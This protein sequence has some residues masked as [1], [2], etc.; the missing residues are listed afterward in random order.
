M[1]QYIKDKRDALLD[2]MLIA[3][4]QLSGLNGPHKNENKEGEKSFASKEL[5]QKIA[6]SLVNASIE[7]MRSPS[8]DIHTS[9]P[10]AAAELARYLDKARTEAGNAM[11]NTVGSVEEPF[12]ALFL[13]KLISRLVPERLPEREH[14]QLTDA[15]EDAGQG[16][17][18]INTISVTT[19]ASNLGQ[20]SERMDSVFELQDSVVRVLAWKRPAT[21]IVS[22]LVFTKICY[23]PMYMALFPILFIVF[24]TCLPHYNRKHTYER[25]F[26]H[27]SGG[28]GRSLFNDLFANRPHNKISTR[29]YSGN[30]ASSTGAEENDDENGNITHGMKV[31]M[32]LRDLQ[33]LTTS[34]LK[35]VD[36][37]SKFLNETAAFTDERKTTW[38]V[39][40]MLFSF[41]LLRSICTF[42][43]WSLVFSS[44]AWI[45]AIA[46]HPKVNALI[47]T[48][49]KKERSQ[50]NDNPEPL[51]EPQNHYDVILDQPP[52]TGEVEIFEI[53]REG[54][55]P[56]TWTFFLF[57]TCLFDLT[58]ESR[59]AQK[60]PPGVKSLDEVDPP[61]GWVFDRNNDW[62]VSHD[63]T[64]WVNDR[65]LDL[66]VEDE[67]M[68]DTVFKRRRLTRRV[69][70]HD[71]NSK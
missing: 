70:K 11:M 19:L 48:I 69:L 18:P 58:D 29:N 27:T 65:N 63:V 24:G 3:E 41:V 20:L 8:T 35:A 32:N 47:K 44:T 59:R 64:T 66:Q 42:I 50:Q 25:R 16:A 17:N 7:R 30:S 39:L 5:L 13:D 6:G 26:G 4:A 62:E 53:F 9:D 68:I 38:L 34:Q 2:S 10:L 23:N 37:I 21:M 33:N 49:K 31:V 15:G 57:S 51:N 55:V 1:R 54:I 36:A 60:P 52:Q 46:I 71:T 22:L 43:N 56:T 14:L 40:G 28:V 12:I 61:E 67:F 45:G